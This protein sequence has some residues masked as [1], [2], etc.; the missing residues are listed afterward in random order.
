MAGERGHSP[1]EGPEHPAGQ[2][3]LRALRQRLSHGLWEHLWVALVVASLVAILH[4]SFGVL[5]WL[6]AAMM[7]I[8]GGGAYAQ[9]VGQAPE[10]REGL[11]V[12]VL[13]SPVAFETA[14]GNRAPLQREVLHD[15]LQ[16]VVNAKPAALV[17][18]LDVSPDTA[19]Q[20]HDPLNTL[21]L[22]AAEH[23]TVVLP[24]PFAVSTPAL[25]EIKATWLADTAAR[26]CAP[27]QDKRDVRF[28]V[29]D[30][31]VR[32]G[33]VNAFEK[34]FPL[35][36]AVAKVDKAQRC[37]KDEKAL[38]VLPAEA[39]SQAQMQRAL[40][41]L[42]PAF[43]PVLHF[44]Q[45]H[46]QSLPFRPG[47]FARPEQV[48]MV[49]DLAQLKSYQAQLAGRQVF[50]GSGYDSR[51]KFLTPYGQHKGTV[52]H[53]AVAYSLTLGVDHLRVWQDYLIDVVVGVLAAV[54]FHHAWLRWGRAQQSLHQATASRWLKAYLLA[55][56]WYLGNLLLALALAGS[57]VYCS[58]V[59]AAPKGLWINPGPVVLGVFVK[60]W[61][62]SKQ[63]IHAGPVHAAQSPLSAWCTDQWLLAAVVVWGW[64][65]VWKH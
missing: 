54:L 63:A 51:D 55:R 35:L 33:L 6:D 29:A 16:V 34:G 57:L 46:V 43:H 9:V 32:Q 56:G 3:G 20:S 4:H 61:L 8:V 58:A 17:L 41:M 50:V 37:T 25:Q 45:A 31:Q 19:A 59:W 65:V 18:D 5:G 47:F 60:S 28:G 13:I 52:L 21:L 62:A 27:G 24:L 36:G 1:G 12:V 64:V 53:A 49:D 48:L 40:A 14:F 15:W 44:Q 23:S 10:A 30:L 42:T 22:K 7:R 11:P 39:A 38:R 26:E 2:G